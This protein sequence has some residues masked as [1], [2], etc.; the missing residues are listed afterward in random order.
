MTTLG[1]YDYGTKWSSYATR[2]FSRT[3]PITRLLTFNRLGLRPV[4]L[5]NWV[6]LPLPT[7][8][9]RGIDR[10]QRILTSRPFYAFT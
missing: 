5:A 3:A 8:T 10:G 7:S 1:C 9:L 6:L 4:A 2:P